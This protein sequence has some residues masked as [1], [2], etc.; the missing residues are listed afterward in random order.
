M[1]DF[2]SNRTDEASGGVHYGSGVPADRAGQGPGEPDPPNDAY[3]G[4]DP[5]V[6]SD[7]GP[8]F[9]LGVAGLD[10]TAPTANPVE[11]S[12]EDDTDR[13]ADAGVDNTRANF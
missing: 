2:E 4:S 8:D 6:R 1:S 5:V 9:G 13:E 7:I 3:T 10:E 11:P 12:R